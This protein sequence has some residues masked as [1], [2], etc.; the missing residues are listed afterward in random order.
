MRGMISSWKRNTHLD[1]ERSPVLR[2]HL[3]RALESGQLLLAVMMP[4]LPIH[5]LNLL[6]EIV[7]ATTSV[8]V[9]LFALEET[10]LVLQILKG[11]FDS[12]SASRQF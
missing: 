10:F 9:V 7:L 1:L 6:Y 5:F 3:P 8:H 4:S 12:F 11:K 2:L